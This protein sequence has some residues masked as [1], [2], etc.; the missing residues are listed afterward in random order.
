MDGGTFSGSDGTGL[1]RVRLRYNQRDLSGQ[2]KFSFDP[3]ESMMPQAM[4]PE[5][6]RPL[7]TGESIHP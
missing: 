7:R 2:R 4:V 5:L 1:M 6:C 3:P